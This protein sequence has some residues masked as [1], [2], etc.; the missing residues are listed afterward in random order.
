MIDLTVKTLD[1]QNHVFSLEDDQITVR[2]FKEYIAETVAV[3]ADSQRLI[4]CGRILQDEKKLN[5]YDVNGKVIH[6]VQRAPPQPGQRGNDGGQSQGQNHG[7]QVWQNPQRTRYRLTRAQMHGNAMYLGAMSVP[8]EIVE[9]H[10]LPV[11]QFSNSLSNGRLIAARHML[12]RADRLMDRLESLS[13][14]VNLAASEN[15]RPSLSELMQESELDT[16]QFLF[17]NTEGATNG[18]TLLTDPTA[19]AI[20]AAFA[21]A[22]ANNA[23]LLRGSSDEN[24]ESGPA[25]ETNE[26]EQ[27]DEQQPQQPQSEQQGS[28]SNNDEQS[29]R[30]SS[31]QLPRPPQLAELLEQLLDTQSRLRPHIDR[32]RKLMRNDPSL[33]PRGRRVE[34]NQRL[35][36]VVSECLHYMSH[37][38]HALSDIIVDMSQQ[39]PRNL[40]CRPIIIQHSA[41]LQPGIPFQVEAHI[42]LHGRNANNNNGNEEN[43]ESGE[44]P[45]QLETNEATTDDA[46]QQQESESATQQQAEQQQQQQQQ[47]PPSLSPFDTVFNLPNSVELLME[48]SPE[49]SIEATTGSEQPPAGENN[50]NSNNNNNN[51]RAGGSS[52]PFSWGSAPPPDFIRNLMQAVAGHMVQGGPTNTRIITRNPLTVS[53]LTVASLDSGTTNAGQSTQARSNVG[54]HPTTATQTRSTSRP[55]VFHQQTHP[56]GVGMSIGQAFDFDPFLSCNSHHIRRTSTTTS[57]TVT[58]RSQGT[59]TNQTT[60]ESQSQTQTATTSSATSNTSST[61][62]TASTTSQTNAIYDPLMYLQQQLLG[63]STSPENL[64]NM[65]QIRTGG[66]IR[67]GVVGNGTN[68][69]AG[70]DLTLADLL[71]RRGIDMSL[72]QSPDSETAE[73]FLANLS[74]LLVQNMTLEGL[75]RL[76]I[77]QSEPISHLRRPLQEL[78]QFSF[79]NIPPETLQEHAT[80]RLLSQLRPHFQTLLNTEENVNGRN[81]SH[82][83]ICATVEALLARH[84]KDILQYLFNNDIDD[85]RFG[86]AIFNIVNNMGRQLCAVL[87]YSIRGGQA[88]LEVIASRFATE[89]LEGIHPT[90]RR[91]MLNAFIVQFRTYSLRVTQPPDS[92]IFPLLIYK[93]VPSEATTMP[94]APVHQPSQIQSEVEPME[95]ETVQERTTFETS[96]LPEDRE[97]IPETFPGHEALPSDWVPIIARDGLRQRRQLQM[98]GITNG[99]VTTLSD[100]Y[101]GT[102]PTKRRKLIEQQKP[103]LLVSPTPNHSAIAASMERLVREGVTRAGVEE[104]EGAA[105]AVAVDPG[106]R[107]AFGQAIRDCLNPHRFGTPDFPDPLRFPNATK[108]F[109]DQDRPPK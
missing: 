47:I 31:T 62:T 65:V 82:V 2:G 108:Y 33:P 57:S 67:P 75:I 34:E 59:R 87:R 79:P 61:N 103:R 105:I 63:D 20:A 56:L 50:N 107:R 66:N 71:E 52:S 45:V 22:D 83:D 98:Q 4:Y 21:E 18:S 42:S 5:D 7:S 64:A 19:A 99:G 23:T 49:G 95:T 100:A 30:R 41:I 46:N 12:E 54:T 68:N 44:T 28:T 77:G 27:S 94:S 43:G 3:P 85:A 70:G 40:R 38:C 29:N 25:N 76:R 11:P 73:N 74:V 53:Q 10:G 35:V 81:G 80:E 86:Q 9:G 60:T 96:A 102:L 1:S 106:V 51:G 37:A 55:H 58:S 6:L 13:C 16:E 32:Y 89:M 109:A 84:I 72:F 36:D 92:E 90:L 17:S 78:F 91:W 39:P 69:S 8:A 101:L 88:G 15:N 24:A 26:E 48:V 104:V 93:D 14:P 97:E